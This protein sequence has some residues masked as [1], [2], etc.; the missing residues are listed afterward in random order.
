MLV[1]PSAKN[2]ECH[3]G[4]GLILSL[5]SESYAS[6]ACH[7]PLFLRFKLCRVTKNEGSAN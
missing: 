6:A 2:K 5:S 4:E 1:R 3:N 7:A